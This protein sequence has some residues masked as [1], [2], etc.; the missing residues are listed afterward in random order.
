M[1]NVVDAQRWFERAVQT[2]RA[3]ADAAA[4]A[5][6]GGNPEAANA[7]RARYL[8]R[9]GSM[10]TT[11]LGNLY[12]DA[13]DYVGAARVLQVRQRVRVGERGLGLEG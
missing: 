13:G 2:E 7:A 12:R 9:H 4:R 5:A 3:G 11:N 1:G 6:G 10:A 8:A